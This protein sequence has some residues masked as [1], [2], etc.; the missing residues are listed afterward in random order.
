MTVKGRL[1]YGGE[2]LL[3]ANMDIDM[4]SKKTQKITVVA[5]VNKQ[6]I[7][8]SG[9]NITSLL[10]MNSRGQHLKIDLKSHV[11]L[12]KNAVGFGSF[13]SY[14]DRHQK[15]K[16][17]GVL[18]SADDSE[19]H[20]LATAPNKEIIRADAK[21]QVHKNLQKLDAEIVVVGN[22]P[23]VANFEAKDWSTF[24]Y[25]E[26]QKGGFQILGK[27]F[28]GSRLLGLLVTH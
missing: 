5:K 6:S 7:D 28:F 22:K 13:L 8:S 24:T 20:L 18:F 4:F 2:H 16:N 26:Y 21:L 23:I 11:A 12:T 3:D 15:P 17:V 9:Y 27:L 25:L 19:I 1:H 14:L 10:E